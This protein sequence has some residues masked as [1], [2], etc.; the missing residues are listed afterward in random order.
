MPDRITSV[1]GMSWFAPVILKL[2]M[3]GEY[4]MAISVA[5]RI[6]ASRMGFL[7][8]GKDA[9]GTYEGV[10]QD[11]QGNT[12][13]EF[14]AGMIEQLPPGYNVTVPDLGHTPEKYCDYRKA[15]LRTIASGLGIMYNSLGNDLESTSYSSARFGR[16][17]E[18]EF[19]RDIQ[20]FYSEQVLNQIF[21]AWLEMAFLSGNLPGVTIDLLDPIVSSVR[22][23][24]R[25]WSYVDPEKDVQAALGAID[26]GLSTHRRELEEQGEDIVEVYDE[27]EEEKQM[28]E[29]RGLVFVNPYSRHPEIMSTQENPEETEAEAVTAGGGKPANGK[30]KP[31]QSVSN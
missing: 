21:N 17:Q 16:D 20:R 22:W 4:E 7:T 3:L 1:R 5:Q 26:G 13:Q 9:E 15:M 30:P 12:V 14:S 27:L 31:T 25:G 28:A 6:A 10:G 8:P 18:V 29:E 23:K 11:A 24:G 2:R 19:W